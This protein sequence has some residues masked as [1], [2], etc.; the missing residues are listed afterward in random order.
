MSVAVSVCAVRDGRGRRLD[1]GV[2]CW[3]SSVGRH[4]RDTQD[5]TAS[6]RYEHIVNMIVALASL[7]LAAWMQTTSAGSLLETRFRH[8]RNVANSTDSSWN[9]QV[10]ATTYMPAASGTCNSHVGA[11]FG[12]IPSNCSCLMSLEDLGETQCCWSA[13]DEHYNLNETILLTVDGY[14]LDDLGSSVQQRVRDAVSAAV[15]TYC[16]DNLHDCHITSDDFQSRILFLGA[17]QPEASSLSLVT[18]VALG[19]NHTAAG[20]HWISLTGKDLERILSLSSDLLVTSFSM[21]LSAMSNWSSVLSV[22]EFCPGPVRTAPSGGRGKLAAIVGG[23]VSGLV[24]VA[25]CAVS[26]RKAIV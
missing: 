17:G 3:L 9:N 2:G 1:A 6:T 25:V 8:R 19:A 23:A 21:A 24:V 4:G 16:S 26:A 10:A 20:N 12:E 14:N 11:M 7:A 5:V 22:E 15:T 18:V 13:L